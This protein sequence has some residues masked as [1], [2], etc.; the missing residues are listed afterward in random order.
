MP[1][2]RRPSTATPP[3]AHRGSMLDGLVR[4]GSRTHCSSRGA[5]HGSRNFTAH[6]AVQCVRPEL[7]RS[8][9]F[10]PHCARSSDSF[11]CTPL[12]EEPHIVKYDHSLQSNNFK[13]IGTHQDGSFVTCI[14]ALSEPD[15]YSGGG[16]CKRRRFRTS[17]LPLACHPLTTCLCP[18]VDRLS[19]P[20]GNDQA[21]DGWRASLPGAARAILRPASRSAN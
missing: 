11:G 9:Q 6:R 20:S 10:K 1:L 13:G 2:G 21:G 14:M 16:T 7:V 19:T 12:S 8:E 4:L 3:Q 15:E 5:G 17:D 18:A